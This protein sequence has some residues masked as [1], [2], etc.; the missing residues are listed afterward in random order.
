MNKPIVLISGASSGIGFTTA[1]Y[2]HEKGC[3]VIGVSRSFPK[4]NYSFKYLLCDITNED[5]IKKL[6]MT[7]LNE[8]GHLDILV[9]AAGMGISGPIE[10]TSQEL[11]QKIYDVNVFGHIHMT[12]HMIEC[13]KKSKRAKII[14][15]SSMASDLALPYQAFYSM[16]KASMDAY[17]KA[18]SLE[19]KPFHIQVTSVLPGDIK[20]GF[21]EHRLKPS[22]DENDPY[23][24]HFKSSLNRM[25]K[26][27]ANG[28]SPLR[29]AKKIHQLI[30]RKHVPLRTTVGLSYKMMR[31]LYRLLPEKLVYWV[32]GKLYG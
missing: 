2:L 5:D 15:I 4:K 16:T 28:M 32:V 6:K 11:I 26:D 19:L 22:L 24:K 10:Y 1:E 14:N 8:Y 30:K 21:T 18:L 31:L 25:E 27:E 9:N 17:T 29:I 20:T 23:T 3:N 13:L 7:I 12:N